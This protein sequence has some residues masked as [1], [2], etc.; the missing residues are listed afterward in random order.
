MEQKAFG[1]FTSDAWGD[2]ITGYT[3]LYTVEGNF[4]GLLGIDMDPDKYQDDVHGMVMVLIE[5]LIITILATA[6]LF[7][8]F[9]FKYAQIEKAK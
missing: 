9:Y 3:P 6:G 5:A 7:L 4:V 8:Y 2:F 1:T